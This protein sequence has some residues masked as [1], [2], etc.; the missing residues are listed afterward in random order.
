MLSKRKLNYEFLLHNKILRQYYLATKD[1]FLEKTFEVYEKHRNKL[2]DE[3]T[4]VWENFQRV[5]IKCVIIKFHN[6]F[7][8]D[9]DMLA[10][11]NDDF[12]NAVVIL[13]KLGYRPEKMMFYK[14][15][16][17]RQIDP[18]LRMHL[19]REVSWHNSIYHD[20]YL[21]WK[22]KKE[23]QMNNNSI[24][25][26]CPE[27]HV[28]TTLAHTI[29]ENGFVTLNDIFEIVRALTTNNVD[30]KYILRTIYEQGWY[31]A[32]LLTI[33]MTNLSDF[34]LEKKNETGID[35]CYP[36]DKKYPAFIPITYYIERCL[37]DVLLKRIRIS[38]VEFV[39]YICKFPVIRLLKRF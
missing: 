20:K 30:R 33:C 38:K 32:F 18:D 27:D 14:V 10:I 2:I 24:Y 19:H 23:L 31:D 34:M 3:L 37:R 16:F 7:H 8:N 11:D 36:Q 1:P 35:N 26:P 28:I 12:N 22:K 25:I 15:M 5:G 4:Y 17:I 21:I 39:E 29:F 9:I 13:K 6:D